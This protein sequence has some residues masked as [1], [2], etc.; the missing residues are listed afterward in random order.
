MNTYK[1]VNYREVQGRRRC[2]VGNWNSLWFP[3]CFH[4]ISPFKNEA[5]HNG[6]VISY[7]TGLV[8]LSIKFVFSSKYTG[9]QRQ[10]TRLIAENKSNNSSRYYYPSLN[11]ITTTQTSTGACETS[12][13][14]SDP[15]I[16][17]TDPNLESLAAFLISAN[18]FFLFNIP[19]LEYQKFEQKKESKEKR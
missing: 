4:I 6:N 15:D 19:A 7:I 2:K 11:R 16:G 1:N 13:T 12:R 3:L 10:K 5:K 14:K 9:H 18:L 17:F 8:C